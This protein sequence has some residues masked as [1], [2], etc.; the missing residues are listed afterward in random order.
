MSLITGQHVQHGPSPHLIALLRQPLEVLYILKITVSLYNK[1]YLLVLT[2][3]EPANSEPPF[4]C[5]IAVPPVW[6]Q[7][8]FRRGF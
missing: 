1:Q 6:Q 7:H 8:L 4:K 3:L 2:M 5:G